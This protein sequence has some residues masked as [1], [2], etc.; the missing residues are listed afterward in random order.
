MLL[1]SS[2]NSWG[3]VAIYEDDEKVILNTSTIRLNELDGSPL[4]RN[5]LAMLLQSSTIREQLG[6]AMTGSCQPNFGPTHLNSV[7]V[8][9]PS[10]HE[11]TEIVT[12][13]ARETAQL[14]ALTAEAQRGIELLQERRTALISA[15]VTGKIDVRGLTATEDR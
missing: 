8:A 11:Q 13:V 3:K 7:M 15:A 9:V 6:L 5:F 14:D 12:F 1:S 2:G 10:Q 4:I